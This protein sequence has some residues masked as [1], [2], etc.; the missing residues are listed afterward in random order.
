MKWQ[1]LK[2]L[3]VHL[4]AIASKVLYI[5]NHKIVLDYVYDLMTIFKRKVLLLELL[6]SED[7]MLNYDTYM[8]Q[9]HNEF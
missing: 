7:I 6:R 8:F 5:Y 4:D 1:I 2:M 3:L 9:K